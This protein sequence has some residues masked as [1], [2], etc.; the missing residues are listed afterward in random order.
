MRQ[1]TF[2]KSKLRSH[3]VVGVTESAVIINDLEIGGAT[4]RTTG[5]AAIR[6][7]YLLEV[8]MRGRLFMKNISI[9]GNSSKMA[10]KDMED[11]LVNNALSDCIRPCHIVGATP[12]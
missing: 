1:A 12:I 7:A 3:P 5:Q 4:P 9:A 2:K 6:I 10:S 8:L 11:E